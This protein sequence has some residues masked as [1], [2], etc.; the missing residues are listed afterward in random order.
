MNKYSSRPKHKLCVIIHMQFLFRNKTLLKSKIKFSSVFETVYKSDSEIVL[1]YQVLFVNS[2]TYCVLSL[3][4]KDF[5]CVIQN[6]V[7]SSKLR[8]GSSTNHVTHQRGREGQ[9]KCVIALPFTTYFRPKLAYKG[10]G[11]SGNGK[12]YRH[13]IFG[14]FIIPSMQ[15]T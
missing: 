5:F 6:K 8:Q 9:V 14:R 10:Q 4:F 3:F 13:V 15:F 1:S 11:G 7:L 2:K 12:N